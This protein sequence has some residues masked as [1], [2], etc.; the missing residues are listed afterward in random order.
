MIDAC[1]AAGGMISDAIPGVIHGHR[2]HLRDAEN[3]EK[4]FRKDNQ[5]PLLPGRL[6]GELLLYRRHNQ[7]WLGA[8]MT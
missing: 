8:N 3:T 4:F 6:C 7:S 1:P 5:K 2:N